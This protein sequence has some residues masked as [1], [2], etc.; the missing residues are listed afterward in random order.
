MGAAMLNLCRGPIEDSDWEEYEEY[1]DEYETDSNAALQD[2]FFVTMRREASL[3]SAA[4]R[5]F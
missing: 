4:S 3:H 5:H 1:E 2:K